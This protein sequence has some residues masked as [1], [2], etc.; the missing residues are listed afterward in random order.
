MGT[1]LFLLYI[2]DHPIGMNTDSKP[3]L[4]AGETR[5]LLTG[6][7]LHDLQVKSVTVLNSTSKWFTVNRLSLNLDKTKVMKFDLNYVQNGSF[8]FFNKDK[9]IKEVTNT[10]FLGLETD[11]NMYWKNHTVHIFT[12]LS[13]ACLAI[14]Y[15]YNFSNIETIKII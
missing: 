11:K 1:L 9:V 8:H 15:M 6:D 7:S 5:V 14:R 2:N 4:N 3:L 13:T 10:K 12:K